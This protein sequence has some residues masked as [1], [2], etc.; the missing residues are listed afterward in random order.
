MATSFRVKQEEKRVSEL[1]AL[2]RGR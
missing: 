2:G 1:D